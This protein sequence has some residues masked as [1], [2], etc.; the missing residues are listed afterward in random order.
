MDDVSSLKILCRWKIF[1]KSL[2]A[3]K[4]PLIGSCFIFISSGQSSPT[5]SSSDSPLL[6]I[7]DFSATLVFAWPAAFFQVGSKPYLF[8]FDRAVWRAYCSMCL[9]TWWFSGSW[10]RQEFQNP[11]EIPTQL[12]KQEPQPN[13]LQFFCYCYWTKSCRLEKKHKITK[14]DTVFHHINLLTYYINWL[15]ISHLC[16]P[17][18]YSVFQVHANSAQPAWLE[19]FEKGFHSAVALVIWG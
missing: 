15:A 19:T 11:K 4:E 9:E 1:M 5:H 16:V 8:K 10:L 14:W 6:D 7:W 18:L 13:C 17:P 12:P 2:V 3:Q